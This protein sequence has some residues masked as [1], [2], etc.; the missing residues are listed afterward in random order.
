[1]GF[2]DEGST[3]IVAGMTIAGWYG[4]EVTRNPKSTIEMAISRCSLPG[5]KM[6]LNMNPASPYHFLYKDYIQSKELIKEGIVKVWQF[7]LEDNPNLPEKYV[8]E[9]IRV[10]KK[11]PLFYKRNI[12]GQWVIAEGA[13]YDMFNEQQHVFTIAPHIDEMNICCDYGV[14]TVTTFGVMGIQKDKQ[15]GNKYFLLDETYYDA[16][17]KGV[18]Q[19][20][21]D[22]VDDLVKL[23][24]KYNLNGNNTIFLPHDAASLKAE[25]KKDKRIK[26]KVKTYAPDTYEDITT[27]QNLFATNRFFINASCKDSITQAQTYCWDIKA[28]QRGEDKPLKD[29][30]HCPDMWRGGILGPRHKGASLR[31]RKGR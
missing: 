8:E 17:I 2:N 30:D 27:I 23:Q 13:I 22:R 18:T 21:S 19:S 9:L 20:D 25:A 24:N 5:A 14:S 4:D 26:M 7:L 12:L 3:D 31:K 15:R 11:N 10:N 28:Q 29:N 6:F 16:E 1:M